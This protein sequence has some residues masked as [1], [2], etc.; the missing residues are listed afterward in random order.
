[1]AT[2]DHVTIRVADLDASL[3]FYT[4]VFELLEFDGDRAEFGGFVEW[5]DF[6]IAAADDEHP[7]TRRLHVG[8]AAASHAQVDGWWHALTE[9]GYA[10]DGRPGPRPEYGPTYY[11]GFV[12]DLD[13]NSV[14]AVLHETTTRR[15]GLVDH[16]WIRVR[17]LAPTRQ[18]Y[19][20]VAP[21]L[22]LQLQ[23]RRGR[24]QLVAEGATV[25]FLEGEP[26]EHLHLAIGVGDHATVDA[27]HEVGLAAGGRDNGGPG[28]RPEYHR[29]YYGAFL[30]D[31]DGTNLEAVHHAR[32]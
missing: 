27:F 16:L 2:I 26:T 17:A 8:F 22:D 24:V 1:M 5:G 4:R 10:D 25:S 29:G 18:L 19:G 6:S 11:G 3:A 30:L 13:D 31:P 28:E 15:P 32:G 21:V 20:E 14:E 12:R 7:P 9:A 23:E